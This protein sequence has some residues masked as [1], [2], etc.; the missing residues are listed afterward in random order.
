LI[1]AL[2]AA[3]CAIG[4][5][6]HAVGLI[7]LKSAIHHVNLASPVFAFDDKDNRDEWYSLLYF[8]RGSRDFNYRRFRGKLGVADSSRTWPFA[9]RGTCAHGKFLWECK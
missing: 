8:P 7:S 1:H 5:P 3:G 4:P 2:S 9:D 6:P